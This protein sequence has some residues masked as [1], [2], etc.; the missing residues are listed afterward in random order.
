MKKVKGFSYDTEKDKDI[1]EHLQKQPNQSQ[2]IWSLVRQ[3]MGKDND[4][5][6]LVKMYVEEILKSKNIKFDD[7]NTN[8]TQKSVMGLLS[9]GKQY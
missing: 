5:E 2:Y 8:I 4:I 7:K 3:D 6:K 9:V 1:I